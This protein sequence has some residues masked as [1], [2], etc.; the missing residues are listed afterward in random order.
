MVFEVLS[1]KINS[2]VSILNVIYPSFS[3]LLKRFCFLN[4]VTF[5]LFFEIYK[6]LWAEGNQLLSWTT[7]K[8]KDTCGSMALMWGQGYWPPTCCSD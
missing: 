1:H 2:N 6:M 5:Q 7:I 8:I 3:L 4:Y